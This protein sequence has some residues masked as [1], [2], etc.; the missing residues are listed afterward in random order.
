M[1]KINKQCKY[2]LIIYIVDQE[3]KKHQCPACGEIND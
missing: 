2:C 1:A 3:Y